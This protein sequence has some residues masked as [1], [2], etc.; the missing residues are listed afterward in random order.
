MVL[1]ETACSWKELPPDHKYVVTRSFAEWS[2][3]PS[4]LAKA[5]GLC[6]RGESYKGL[7][8]T[9][10]DACRLKWLKERSSVPFTVLEAWHTACAFALDDVPTGVDKRV[11]TALTLLDAVNMPD[12]RLAVKALPI[13]ARSVIALGEIGV[14]RTLS[15]VLHS[16][17]MPDPHMVAVAFEKQ[18][19]FIFEHRVYCL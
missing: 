5:W 10:E 4:T 18:L 2:S 13:A 1:A 11:E 9:D 6:Q 16:L 14:A 12:I 19:C 8:I 7:H 15:T 17:C 3:N